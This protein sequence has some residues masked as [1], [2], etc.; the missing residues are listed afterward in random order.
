MNMAERLRQSGREEGR[1]EG[2]QEGMQEGMLKGRQEGRQEGI[3]KTARAF[4][5]A[6][7]DRA[8]IMHCTGLTEQQLEKL[9]H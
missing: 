4:L 6:G 7:V 1:Q 9:L 2:V 3:E 8:V 5:A